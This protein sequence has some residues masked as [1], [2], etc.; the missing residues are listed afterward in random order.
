[1]DDCRT[2]LQVVVRL[3]TLFGDILGDTFTVSTF[4][5]TGAKVSEPM[6]YPG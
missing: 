1:M 2:Q 3:D 6:R 4:E 5:L